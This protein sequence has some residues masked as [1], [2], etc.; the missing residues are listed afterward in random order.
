MQ[1]RTIPWCTIIL[2]LGTLSSNFLVFLGNQWTSDAFRQI[3]L[4]TKG[5]SNVGLGIAESLREE[6]DEKMNN[7][8]A[9][10]LEA[11][12]RVQS[13][14]DGLDQV[15][16]MAGNQT[17]EAINN[18]AELS[19]LEMHG[20]EQGLA[21]IQELHGKNS[22][23]VANLTPVIINAVVEVIELVFAKVNTTMFAL[24]DKLKPALIQ[25][26][27][28]VSKFG[29]KVTNGLEEFSQTLDKAQKIFDQV[30]KQLNK[31][32]GKNEE[33]MLYQT[34]PLFD[35]D[36]SGSVQVE[37]L[38]DVGAWYSIS[39]LRGKK[40][41]Q[42]MKKYDTSGDG[43]IDKSEFFALVNDP[44]IT[45][46]M[47]IIL[48][49]Y[50]RKLAE[51]GGTV[52]QAR[53]RD[54][55]A[56]AVANYIGLVCAK[57]MT[58]VGWIAD[59]LTNQ[60]LSLDFTGN[61]LVQMCLSKQDPHAP[62]FTTAD[63]GELLVGDMMR[64]QPQA[65]LDAVD[66]M[67]NTTW[68]HSQGFAV[69]T[70][71][72]CVQMATQ[73]ITTAETGSQANVSN[74]SLQQEEAE[75]GLLSL[76]SVGES[77]KM[78][79]EERTQ[80]IASLPGT[81]YS[82]AEE[83][84]KLFHLERSDAR[85]KRRNVLFASKTSQVLL[86]QLLGGKA[87]SDVQSSSA[88]EE[89]LNGGIPSKPVTLEFAK[90]LMWNATS[91]S[92]ERM[93]MAADY[94]GDSS[95][96]ADDFASKI[97]GMVKKVESFIAMMQQYSTPKGV[98]ALEAK[99]EGFLSNALGD[100]KQIIEKRLVDLI[101]KTGPEI[102]EAV[103]KAAHDAGV[104]L[105]TLLGKA[106]VSPL[107]KALG[108]PMKKALSEGLQSEEM[109]EALG[110][111]LSKSLSN[112]IVNMSSKTVGQKLGDALDQL[113]DDAIVQGSDAIENAEKKLPG[114]AS[115]LEAKV[116][117]DLSFDL[118][119]D[120]EV[121]F[122]FSNERLKPRAHPLV[123]LE[124]L[125]RESVSMPDAASNAWSS[126]VN[127]LR[128]FSN[129]LPKATQALKDAR[130]EVSK[131]SSTLDSV[132]KGF[133][134]SGTHVFDTIA[135]LWSTVWI[136]YF[137][138]ILPFAI[139]DL[140]YGFWAHGWFGGP[141]PI[142]RQDVAAAPDT[143]LS[144]CSLLCSSCCYWV[145]SFHDTDTCFWSIVIFM[146]VIVLVTFIIAIALAIFA[147]V[148]AFLLA[149]CSMVYILQDEEVCQG[150][151]GTMSSFLDTFHIHGTLNLSD[152]AINK[153]CNDHA[154]VTCSAIQGMMLRSTIYTVVFSLLGA[155]FGLQM[156]F[157]SATLHEQAVFRRQ[158]ASKQQLKSE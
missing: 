72:G 35:A 39:A 31:D 123:F 40:P 8:S 120:R 102:E 126:M 10:L 121:E 111:E 157:D 58:K 36:G 51:I 84:V 143:F 6:L 104:R 95:N 75:L 80:F 112:A 81:A 69:S 19:L 78:T 73:W 145:R 158:R 22:S 147:G 34:F 25:V 100:V 20:P 131:L 74:V 146:Q 3:G 9:M 139:L 98:M 43:S 110:E 119:L 63:P 24:M 59:R 4:G 42:L 117:Q 91:T 85:Q 28:W 107:G 2:V 136:L 109:G 108:E 148:K 45:G 14:Q 124:S 52:G 92:H 41:A 129:L 61:V 96:P 68:Y 50:A 67:A 56:K 77:Q 13:T 64:L 103:H 60:S 105:G 151:L 11:L 140:C 82:L 94:A 33:E 5:W 70:Q 1:E 17:D 115:L 47:S 7:V 127:Q 156:L 38:L 138:F 97:N 48:R 141:K 57:N 113:L 16:S 65:V 46:S 88:V 125:D 62:V 128:S 93:R 137:F 99:I 152:H 71:P 153:Q 37:E 87:P 150:S 83:G 27:K 122:L 76:L 79:S 134:T 49:R 106:M 86:A 116:E 101:E 54:E 118:A 32:A 66:L 114:A 44:S 26:G 130:K 30:M 55:I 15:L 23:H 18:S 89:A 132:F 21:L 53:M 135:G 12:E 29:A 149:G 154:L 142:D 155:I 90:F 133:S 144:K